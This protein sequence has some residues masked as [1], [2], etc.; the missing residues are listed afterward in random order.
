MMHDGSPSPV[1][2]GLE[3]G[4][5]R[6]FGGALF[7]EAQERS[8]GV[9]HPLSL[10]ASLPALLTHARARRPM[11]L[12]QTRMGDICCR[13]QRHLQSSPNKTPCRLCPVTHSARA[14]LA[15]YPPRMFADDILL[16][17]PL[18]RAGA[19]ASTTQTNP[20]HVRVMKTCARHMSSRT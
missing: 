2:S 19:A 17:P 3:V 20:F 1:Q 5:W 9:R 15:P 14:P 7:Y 13:A 8:A 16:R 18:A 6:E 10:P 4:V 11:V 12:V